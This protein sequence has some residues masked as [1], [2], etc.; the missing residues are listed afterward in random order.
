MVKDIAMA[1]NPPTDNPATE[2]PPTIK[3]I[4]TKTEVVKH[5]TTLT[6]SVAPEEE[7]EF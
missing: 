3:D 4:P 1:E 6:G 7:K 5:D 2:N